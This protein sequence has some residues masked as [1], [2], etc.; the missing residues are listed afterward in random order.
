MNRDNI[1][2]ILDRPQIAANIATASRAM[3]NFGFFKLRMVAPKTLEKTH[4]MAKAGTVVLEKAE[5]FSSL[6]QAVDDLHWVIGTTGRE[7]VRDE[8][9]YSPPQAVEKLAKVSSNQ[10]VGLLFGH[11]TSGLSN[12]QMDFMDQLVHIPTNPDFPSLNLAHSVS[13]LCWEL[14]QQDTPLETWTKTV[15]THQKRQLLFDKLFAL[16]NTVEV[17]PEGRK[18]VLHEGIK[19]FLNRDPIDDRDLSLLLRAFNLFQKHLDEKTITVKE[20]DKV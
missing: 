2:I 10:K 7:D 18:R 12:A 14:S 17:V 20:E 5:V 6:A 1:Y 16:M 13:I 4:A 11:E 3:A 8:T 15:P 9:L 19:R